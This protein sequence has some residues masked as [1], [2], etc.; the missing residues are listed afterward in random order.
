MAKKEQLDFGQIEVDGDMDFDSWEDSFMQEPA[1]KKDRGVVLE[2][3]SGLAEG[4]VSEVANAE[5]VRKFLRNSLPEGY[6]EAWD[7]VDKI[8]GTV[9]DLYDTAVKELKPGLGVIATKIDRLVP[10]DSKIAKSVT[11]KIKD[12]FGSDYKNYGE[13]AKSRQDKAVADMVQ[14]VFTTQMQQQEKQHLE[15]AAESKV[16]KAIEKKRFDI[17]A[18]IFARMEEST[19]K[20]AEYTTTFNMQFQKKSLELQYR[21]YLTTVD[22]L[23]HIQKSSEINKQ[24]LEAVVKNTAMPEFVKLKMSERLHELTRDKLFTKAS[25]ALFG[26]SDRIGQGLNRAKNSF[27]DLIFSVKQGVE[28]GIMGADALE[29]VLEMQKNEAE[30][31]GRDG[32]N[33]FKKTGA[34]AGAAGVGWMRNKASD[35]LRESAYD[36]E[37]IM[38]GSHKASI[39]ARSPDRILSKIL[40]SDAMDD[41]KYNYGSPMHFMQQAFKNLLYG[42]GEKTPGG[43]ISLDP[44]VDGK[45]ILNPVYDDER[46]R[47]A[48]IDVIPG[49]LA[50]ILREVTVANTG[51]PNTKLLHYDIKDAKFKTMAQMTKDIQDTIKKQIKSGNFSYA[52]ES[53]VR[54]LA[55]DDITEQERKDLG[56]MVGKVAMSK[57]LRGEGGLLKDYTGDLNILRETSE[58]KALSDREKELFEKHIL[59]ALEGDTAAAY[60]KKNKFDK[61]VLDMRS[62]GG[63]I[64][65]ELKQRAAAGQQEALIASGYV[66]PSEDGKSGDVNMDLYN[67][68]LH[69]PLQ[70]SGSD[71]NIKERVKPT[72]RKDILAVFKDKTK[73]LFAA[74]SESTPEVTSDVNTKEDVSAF[75]QDGEAPITAKVK[76]N[77]KRAGSVFRQ[78]FAGKKQ[79]Q[80]QGIATSDANAKEEVQPA[81]PKGILERMRGIKIFNWQYK[82]GK[83]SQASK[84]A[85]G[86]ETTHTGPMAQTVNAKLGADAAP[87]GTKLDLISMNGYSMAAIQE[88]ADR[89]DSI[90]REVPLLKNI[91]AKKAGKKQEEALAATQ[92]GQPQEPTSESPQ[93][94]A[95]QASAQ[96]PKKQGW[97]TRAVNAVSAYFQPKDATV[98]SQ[99]QQQ[100]PQP[101]QAVSAQAAPVENKPG[102]TESIFNTLQE[103]VDKARNVLVDLLTTKAKEEASTP[104]SQE[105][106]VEQAK[107]DPLV[108][109]LKESNELKQE[110]TTVLGKVLNWL[111]AKAPKY[112]E[113]EQP[114]QAQ[115]V[116]TQEAVEK[117]N[118]EGLTELDYLK[119]ITENTDSLIELANSGKGIVVQGQGGGN[120]AGVR[121]G[122]AYVDGFTQL[123]QLGL[124]LIGKGAF[125]T[126]S[127]VIKGGNATAK[128]T[129]E[130]LDKHKESIKDAG[131]WVFNSIADLTIKG[132][133][134][135]KKTLTEYIPKGLTD[136]KAMGK[137]IGKL[138]EKFLNG[139]E[140]IYIAGMESPVITKALMKAGYYTDA[141]TGKVIETVDDIYAAAG[142]IKDATGTIVLTLQQRTLGIF[143]GKGRRLKSFG[144]KMGSLA[145]VG[146]SWVG[147]K[148]VQGATALFDKAKGAEFKIPGLDWAKD[149]LSGIKDSIT[150]IG[151]YDRRSYDVLVQ[152]R[153]L[154]AVGKPKKLVQSI[155]D[156]KVGHTPTKDFKP[157]EAKEKQLDK[158][159]TEKF[160]KA[161]EQNEGKESDEIDLKQKWSE[162]TSSLKELFGVK[163]GDSSSSGTKDGRQ[164]ELFPQL[165][166][167]P[168]GKVLDMMDPKKGPTLKERAVGLKNKFK[169]A[170]D[171]KKPEPSDGQMSLFD[172]SKPVIEQKPKG[173]LA[174]FLGRMQDAWSGK[175][176]QETPVATDGQMDMFD[177]P[178]APVVDKQDTPSNSPP[179]KP[180]GRLT[181]MLETGKRWITGDREKTAEPVNNIAPQDAQQDMFAAPEQT[182]PAATPQE[183]VKEGFFKRMG[184]RIAKKAR[185]IDEKLGQKFDDYVE[186]KT[187]EQP[188]IGHEEQAAPK[189]SLFKRF[190]NKVTDKVSEQA[191]KLERRLN[192]YRAKKEQEPD[193]LEEKPGL[194]EGTKQKFDGAKRW[195]QDK[196]KAVTESKSYQEKLLPRVQQ[197]TDMLGRMFK[198]LRQAN[199]D[200]AGGIVGGDQTVGEIGRNVASSKIVQ[201]IKDKLSSP[202]TVRD[203][204]SSAKGFVD[205]SKEF[206][207]DKAAQAKETAKQR[208]TEGMTLFREKANSVKERASQYKDKLLQRFGPKQDQLDIGGEKH[209][210][211][212][213][214][215]QKLRDAKLW[216][217]DKLAP[218]TNSKAYREV[219]APGMRGLGQDLKE[220]AQLVKALGPEAKEWYKDTVTG[221]KRTGK[222]IS[223][224]QIAELIREGGS[225]LKDAFNNSPT[226]QKAI[227]KAKGVK[228]SSKQFVLD[229]V[230]QAKDTAKQRAL[231]GRTFFKQKADAIKEKAEDFADKFSQS[232]VA[233]T[234]KEMGSRTLLQNAQLARDKLDDKVQHYNTKAKDSLMKQLDKHPRLKEAVMSRLEPRQQELSL[235]PHGLNKPTVMDRVKHAG[236]KVAAAVQD[237]TGW[238][239]DTA[240]GKA[241][242]RLAQKGR[243]KLQEQARKI[244]ESGVWDEIQELERTE[245]DKVDDKRAKRL[246]NN[247]SFVGKMFKYVQDAAAKVS[248]SKAVQPGDTASQIVAQTQESSAPGVMARMLQSAKAGIRSKAAQLGGIKVGDDQA[249]AA[250]EAASQEQSQAPAQADGA[251]GAAPAQGQP[252]TAGQPA[253]TTVAPGQRKK[254]FFGRMAGRAR[255]TGGRLLGSIRRQV[256]GELSEEEQND[257]SMRGR[258]KRVGRTAISSI[259]SAVGAG[260]KGLLGAGG[261]NAGG[262]Q[263]GVVSHEAQQESVAKEV[264]RSVGKVPTAFD[265]DK[266]GRRDGHFTEQL[267]KQ[268]KEKAERENKAKQEQKE[269]EE[270]ANTGPKYRSEQNVI[271]TMLEKAGSVFSFLKDT[272]GGLFSGGGLMKLLGGALGGVGKLLT[273]ALGGLAKVGAPIKSALQFAG[274]AGKLIPGVAK[275]ARIANIA[276]TAVTVGGLAFGGAGGAVLAG[277]SLAISAVTTALASP[278][279]LGALAAGAV[280]YGA[281]KAYKYFTRNSLNEWEKL[282]VIQYGLDGTSDTKEH[283]SK[284]MNLEGYLQD[285]RTGYDNGKAKLLD[286]KIDHKEL[287]GFFDIDEKDEDAVNN[288]AKWFGERFKPFYLNTVTAL[289]SVD[290]KLKLD[291]IPKMDPEKQRDFLNR[292][293]FFDGPYDIDTSPIKGL[294]GLNTGTSAAKAQIKEL[295]VKLGE[296]K[297]NEKKDSKEED[298]E[299]KLKAAKKKEDEL[300]AKLKE[301]QDKKNSS[302]PPIP[303]AAPVQQQSEAEKQQQTNKVKEQ[304]GK[305]AAGAAIGQEPTGEDGKAPPDTTKANPDNKEDG[306]SGA[307]GTKLVTATGPL[308]GGEGGM[309]FMKL[310][311]DTKLQGLHPTFLKMF[312]AMAQEYG[313][314]TGKSITINEAFRTYEDQAYLHK[315]M[316]RKAA[317]PGHSMHEKGLALDVSTK[318]LTELERL[319]LMR[320]YGFTRP[321]GG[322][323]HHVESSGVQMNIEK[324]KSDPGYA[325]MQIRA[326]AG[327]GGGGF[328]TMKGSALK[329]RNAKVARTVFESGTTVTIDLEKEKEKSQAANDPS[330]AK[331]ASA[332]KPGTLPAAED[333]PKSSAG[334]ASPGGDGGKTNVV[335]TDAAKNGLGSKEASMTAADTPS[336]AGKQAG[337]MDK[338]ES[339]TYNSAAADYEP[340]PKQTQTTP[341][342]D[343]PNGYKAI[344]DAV[345]PPVTN[346]PEQATASKPMPKSKE[347]TKQ[348]IAT[349]AKETR[350]PAPVLQTFAAIESSMNPDPKKTGTSSAAGAFQFLKATWQEVLRKYGAKYGLGPGASPKDLRAAT[351]MASEYIEQ[352]KRAI[353][354]VKPSPNT[355]DLYMAHF[356]GAGGARTFF[357]A[358]PEENASRVMPRAARSNPGIFKDKGRDLTI[359]QVYQNIVKKVTTRAREY[360]IA[361][362][363][364][365]GSLGG[366]SAS[367]VP[368]SSSTGTGGGGNSATPSVAH[369]ATYKKDAAS[370]TPAIG[371]SA[372]AAPS[373]S[374]TSTPAQSSA[375]PGLAKPQSPPA[376]VA[377][378]SAFQSSDGPSAS[379]AKSYPWMVKDRPDDLALGKSSASTRQEADHKSMS[380]V[381]DAMMQQL[382]IQKQTHDVLNNRV[383]PAL[384]EMLNIIKSNSG[385][386]G[387]GAKPSATGEPA[388]APAPK[389]G[390]PTRAATPSALDLRRT[391]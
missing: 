124:G 281:Y 298:P 285:G 113:G 234:V 270:R 51:D 256:T 150:G 105:P 59:A 280:A 213:G 35:A 135:G 272:I 4:V 214:V 101:A 50:R 194:F 91:L 100:P 117:K 351:L 29:M 353:S 343:S 313:E 297:V 45:D 153:D 211:F 184:G 332:N 286:K 327:R 210:I 196:L 357:K 114:S 307:G 170:W 389:G 158:Q 183:P 295:E 21:S 247:K 27:K 55:K 372:A 271:D 328:G 274:N 341:A 305:Q 200:I 133:E 382:A 134:L 311:K 70:P 23:N 107:K 136:I 126:G 102:V 120:F 52:R 192:E 148:V 152:I 195:A 10:D 174:Q 360:G 79:E 316:P 8:S 239:A 16:D 359:G 242:G 302:I 119:A 346:S 171:G 176:P 225:E 350:T 369:P 278:V 37:E 116:Q 347:E 250:Q 243:K 104:T 85:G 290:P 72:N 132:L 218:I 383:A 202:P 251:T 168:L 88:L 364:N 306:G 384:E 288:F 62:G 179:A 333:K 177:Q 111:G 209:S 86:G 263:D 110:Q 277:T 63:D 96:E 282:R 187:K 321:V 201:K 217:K 219:L 12:W 223:E 69:Q 206:L 248:K 34:M 61:A 236:S 356:L 76:K 143:D 127:A 54:D 75:G 122:N 161:L 9:V 276:R 253:N 46:S 361:L 237:K 83:E 241:A 43:R 13:D 99:T 326:S 144:K 231:E 221:L 380:G 41:D 181:R 287:L 163:G 260:V 173:K 296:K 189:E 147:K 156:R 388:P 142:D 376:A 74:Q 324:A 175:K 193:V 146:A 312:S 131:K 1:A 66:K 178:E 299:Q 28:A 367:S 67:H 368:S 65:N 165:G 128:A 167:S 95:E 53:A 366:S 141:A 73:S 269:A 164:G 349:Y 338:A 203:L 329:R 283:N 71:V 157:T 379:S 58:F 240:A 330:L 275:V 78:F 198:D 331:G 310:S 212:Q 304:L 314:T 246:A 233:K 279:V 259:G 42:F 257:N 182:T 139:A 145:W 215:K 336:S 57:D 97:G 106:A 309:Q 267:E 172:E 342:N 371:S 48:Q 375:V 162:F 77:L 362:T 2:V 273:G 68:Q 344:A 188:P 115:A 264:R 261:A 49:Y 17:S 258:L 6:G 308:K 11:S 39:Y 291:G 335:S 56:V 228:D 227:A 18:N 370:S 352:N 94:Q 32:V 30:M 386:V 154:L 197:K 262:A 155:L 5:N 378:G 191:G 358:K 249:P 300:K 226:V 317:K 289:F 36:E 186:G 208:A 355:A 320:K 222:E 390:V 374:S 284:M 109:E 81:Q 322:E 224:S 365:M 391:A 387:G 244:R 149:K 138:F 137:K 3:A 266:D 14:G 293:S 130:F 180:K 268:E 112:K 294:P 84:E 340:K 303:Q 229:K 87:G 377:E 151:F 339:A 82:K 373:T 31:E 44:G 20:T 25:E 108:Q 40:K 345:A 169:D 33:W 385:A 354:S 90:I 121:T 93:V 216:G 160:E 319:G 265:S 348:Q 363:E 38:K 92:E 204:A 230:Q 15:N 7:G 255:S 232:K 123:A 80:V 125:D 190:K 323:T 315:T 64:L 381:S 103:S 220:G 235:D 337:G 325:D 252:T 199:S 245:S 24:Q 238:M 89:V 47:R 207:A 140:D 22:L 159:K 166:E 205:S 19:K 185:E 318:D 118:R 98:V 26:G 301:E 129:G 292:A 60:E 334:A 254:G